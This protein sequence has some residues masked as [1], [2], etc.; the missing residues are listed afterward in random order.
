MI[1]VGTVEM[2]ALKPLVGRRVRVEGD[3]TSFDAEVVEVAPM[4]E[5]R[6]PNG[7]MPFSVV[8]RGPQTAEPLQQTYR[9][10]GEATGTMEL[11][12]VPIG[13]DEHGMKYEAVFT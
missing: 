5:T 10:E 4:G 3:E 1:D 11:F 7:R 9:V 8:L 13:P 2:E 12:L 6:G